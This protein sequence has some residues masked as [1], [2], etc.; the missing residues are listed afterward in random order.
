MRLQGTG[1]E[2]WEH[3]RKNTPPGANRGAETMEWN[4][5]GLSYKWSHKG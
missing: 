2:T 3:T 4:R 5:D 1:A